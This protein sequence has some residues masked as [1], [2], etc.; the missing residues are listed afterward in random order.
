LLEARDRPCTTSSAQ[1]MTEVC[2]MAGRLSNVVN[3]AIH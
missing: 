2:R 1:S 3:L